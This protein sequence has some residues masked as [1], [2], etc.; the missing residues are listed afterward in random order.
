MLLAR[1]VAS[2]LPSDFLESSAGTVQV[3]GENKLLTGGFKR[4]MIDGKRPALDPTKFRTVVS[5]DSEP[6][7]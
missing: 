3:P 5:D 1:F 4:T 2:V 7:I 6:K